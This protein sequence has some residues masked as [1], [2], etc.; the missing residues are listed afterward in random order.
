MDRRRR[1]TATRGKDP[2][3]TTPLPV[4]GANPQFD[5]PRVDPSNDNEVRLLPLPEFVEPVTA[6]TRTSYP[7]MKPPHVP[8]PT[9]IVVDLSD[10][11]SF[12]SFVLANT[13]GTSPT[14]IVTECNATMLRQSTITVTG[15]CQIGFE[16]EHLNVASAS[17]LF[18]VVPP[19]T[20]R[21]LKLTTRCSVWAQA[22]S[23][24]AFVNVVT[25]YWDQ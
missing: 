19:A 18:I 20:T 11:L 15:P 1:L 25:E 16:A 22:T 14:Q 12:E 21:E 5:E 13:A 4:N 7:G 8:R 23:G 17:G 6:L 3:V 10:T 24:T 9:S 2:S